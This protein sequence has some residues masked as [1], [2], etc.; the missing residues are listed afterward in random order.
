MLC[1]GLRVSAVIQCH[2]CRQQSTLHMQTLTLGTVQTFG[3]VAA[4]NLQQSD[5]PADVI[6]KRHTNRADLSHSACSALGCRVFGPRGRRVKAA[7]G[8]EQAA[9]CGSRFSPA[10]SKTDF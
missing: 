9:Q 6:P 4:T 5:R 1:M 3:F 8:P 10:C 2:S 7:S